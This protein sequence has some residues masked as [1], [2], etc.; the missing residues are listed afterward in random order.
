MILIQYLSKKA[1]NQLNG[2]DSEEL[3]K[4]ALMCTKTELNFNSACFLL[5]DSRVTV[6]RSLYRG[7]ESKQLHDWRPVILTV[8]VLNTTISNFRLLQ[9]TK[10]VLPTSLSIS[11]T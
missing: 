7:N 2:L 4:C 11:P 5:I 1:D 3:L 10:T 6:Y 8:F 9:I